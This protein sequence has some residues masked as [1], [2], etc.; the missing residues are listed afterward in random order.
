MIR[1]L[2]AA[3]IRLYREGLA[4]VL[5]QK[6]Q[7][8]G[9][10][11]NLRQTLKRV[12]DGGF[13]VILLDTMMSGSLSAIKLIVAI[14]PR[15]KVVALTVPNVEATVVA[16]A[17]AGI[18]G[19]VLR[20]ASLTDLF[21][22]IGAAMRGE[23]TCSPRIAKCLLRRVNVL[24]ADRPSSL[25]SPRLTSRELEIVELIDGGLSNKDIAKELRIAVSTVKNHVHNIL[26][27]LH[28]HRRGAAAAQLRHLFVDDTPLVE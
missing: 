9:T 3:D 1:V 15:I 8:V 26:R 17:E 18:S 14:D 25:H 28:T 24:A 20:D 13:D 6:F 2:V 19:Y 16:C 21:D 22:A 27:K 10:T 5:R 4:E 11:G 23:L 12:R 7:V